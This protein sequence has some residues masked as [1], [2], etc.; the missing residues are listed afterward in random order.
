V[1]K[2]AK[3]FPKLISYGPKCRQPFVGRALDSSGISEAVVQLLSGTEEHRAG[4]TRTVAK[5]DDV[6]KWLPVELRD[7]F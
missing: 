3:V 6:I 7:V 4:F 2:T 1:T 5:R